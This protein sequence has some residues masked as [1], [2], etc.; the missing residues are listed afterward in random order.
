MYIN[1]ILFQV[2]T[3]YWHSNEIREESMAI[4]AAVYDSSFLDFTIPMKRKLVLIMVRAQRPL[5]IKV[6]A[7]APMTLEMF[8]SL[9][10]NAYS[11]F[12]IIRTI[13]KK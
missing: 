2:F 9:L 7:W 4:S 6:G 5:E 8:Q 12:N 3:W 11:Y 13:N 1:T 10:V